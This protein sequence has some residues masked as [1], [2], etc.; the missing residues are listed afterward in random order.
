MKKIL[1]VLIGIILS[2]CSPIDSVKPFDCHQA[3]IL[4]GQEPP[5]KTT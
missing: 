1:L 4:L 2:A 3:A 5:Q